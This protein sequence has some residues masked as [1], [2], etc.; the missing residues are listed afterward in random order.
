MRLALFSVPKISISVM[1]SLVLAACGSDTSNDSD[2][3]S[4]SKARLIAHDGA[5]YSLSNTQLVRINIGNPADPVITDDIWVGDNPD[6]LAQ[7]GDVIYVGSPADIRSY[8]YT[9]GNGLQLVDVSDPRRAVFDPVVVDGDYAY[10]TVVTRNWVNSEGEVSGQGDLYVYQIDESDNLNEISV[11]Q[12]IG[13][14]Q[15]LAIWD[16]N[17]MI[18][19]PSNGL[20][21]MDVSN[22]TSPLKYHRIGFVKCDDILHVGDGHFI[23][24][25]PE[26]LY[27][28]KPY[29]NNN[30]G[31]ISL[32]K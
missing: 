25:G 23:T 15:G 12:N 24:V 5:I 19:D 11:V 21:H 8:R 7:S 31:V 27:Q 1:L 30:M 26:G 6:S 17:L 9:E 14:A 2:G 28:L 16:D 10:S 13:Y 29:E 3:V 20:L 4:G 32:Y 22:R 18:C